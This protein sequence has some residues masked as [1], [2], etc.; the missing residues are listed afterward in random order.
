MWHALPASFVIPVEAPR[1]HFR[2]SARA[3]F[4]YGCVY[5]VGGAYLTFHGI[6]V[7]GATDGGRF[8]Y[9][10]TSLFVLAGLMLLILIPYLLRRRRARF[11]RWILSRRDFARIL[12]VFMAYRAYAVGRVAVRGD[13]ASV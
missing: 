7:R 6:G 5:L 8:R 9:V 10:M 2:T 1:D 12:S 13:A 11:E 4:L 3:Y